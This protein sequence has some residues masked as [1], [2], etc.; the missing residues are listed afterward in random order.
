M[1]TQKH[2]RAAAL[3]L[4]LATLG[5]GLP[6]HADDHA[7]QRIVPPP[8]YQQEC[9]VCHIAYPPGLLPAASW[10]SLMGK[11]QHHFGSDASLDP[12]STKELATWLQLNAGTSKRVRRDPTP[13]PEDRI[14]RAA[15][16][17]RKH[18]E[19]SS[20]T[21]RLA[22]VKSAAN[23]SACHPQADQGDFNEHRIRIPR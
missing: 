1:S 21:W 20:A 11:L 8:K 18:D 22:S 12:A 10:Q 5:F 7:L 3:C 17:K 13:P 16:F 9:A 14:T 6:V 2:Q 19:V 4:A 15:W 23:C